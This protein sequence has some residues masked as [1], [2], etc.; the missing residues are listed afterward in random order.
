MQAIASQNQ[1]AGTISPLS[2][3]PFISLPAAAR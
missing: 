2:D 3:D 1:D